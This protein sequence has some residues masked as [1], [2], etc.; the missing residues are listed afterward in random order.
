MTSQSIL[1]VR[2]GSTPLGP[3]PQLS[4]CLEN[5]DNI[6]VKQIIMHARRKGIKT[7]IKIKS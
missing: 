4:I 6:A 7:E 2:I 3:N 5:R 1:T